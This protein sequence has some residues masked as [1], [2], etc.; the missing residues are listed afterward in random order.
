MR[1]WNVIGWREEG[2]MTGN[3]E[4]WKDSNGSS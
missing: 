1:G 4:L 3:V 2:K